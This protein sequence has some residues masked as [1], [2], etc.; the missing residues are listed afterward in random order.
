MALIALRRKALSVL[1]YAGKL[2]K[3]A[4]DKAT[5]SAWAR[6]RSDLRRRS[7]FEFVQPWV[8]ELQIRSEKDDKRLQAEIATQLIAT[9][10]RILDTV[11][12]NT[13]SDL[14]GGVHTLHVAELQPAAV[15]QIKMKLKH[16]AIRSLS[17]V[18]SVTYGFLK[19]MKDQPTTCQRQE[20]EAIAELFT[21]TYGSE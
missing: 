18:K 6:R 9:Y 8:I 16:D 14:N 19:D 4:T 3:W 20:D 21:C 7:T 12:S 15:A 2:I 13:V 11:A 5:F 17:T 1:H 10:S